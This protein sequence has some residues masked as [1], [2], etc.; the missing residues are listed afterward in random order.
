MEYGECAFVSLSHLLRMVVLSQR[1]VD[2]AT[3]AYELHDP[4]FHF[5]LQ[6]TERNLR[7][8]QSLVAERGRTLQAGGSTLDDRSV[9]GSCTLRIY[10]ALQITFAAA[11]EI[12]HNASFTQE[13]G[14]RSEHSSARW[15]DAARLANSLVTLN[16]VALLKRQRSAA[17]LVLR[18][19]HHPGW[20][21]KL[22][23]TAGEQAMRQAEASAA[24][25]ECVALCLREIVDQAYEIARSIV[26]WL[27]SEG[28]SDR[29]E[30]AVFLRQVSAER[31]MACTGGRSMIASHVRIGAWGFAGDGLLAEWDAT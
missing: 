10:S 7:D 15:R 27:A 11:R 8:L 25:E 23:L 18:S 9:S 12:A 19:R 29:T 30:S 24:P 16:A 4:R 3:K 28:C 2:Y 6:D 26:R 20:P 14:Q 17:E 5:Q 1:A 21:R 13:N 31:R 22:A